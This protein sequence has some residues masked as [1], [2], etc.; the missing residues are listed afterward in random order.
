M[1]PNNILTRVLTKPLH[2]MLRYLF[3]SEKHLKAGIITIVLLAALALFYKYLIVIFFIMLGAVSLIHTIWTKNY[4]GFE[5]CILATVICAIKF[6]PLVGALVGATSIVLGLI[7]STNLDAGLFLAAIMFGAVGIIASFF[8][9]Q[10]VLFAGM[11]CAI[12]YDFVMV[13]FYLLMGSSPVT[14]GV[15]FV[16]HM[17][18]TYY[19][20]TFLAPVLINII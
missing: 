4:F 1:Q 10:Q 6:G 18:T 9:F 7:L 11:L 16:T 3:K 13:G 8:T 14:S 12:V 17:L 19:V 2:Y 15:Y 20:F 5:L